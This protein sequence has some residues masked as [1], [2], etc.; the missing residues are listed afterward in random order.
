M[1][2]TSG[3][4]EP[5]R[6]TAGI[7]DS[8]PRWSPDGKRLAFVRNAE[9]DGKPQPSQIYF[10]PMDGGEARALANLPKAALSPA[11]APDGKTVAFTTTATADDVK[12]AREERER[13][14]GQEKRVKQ[15]AQEKRE[16]QEGQERREGQDGR[17]RKSDVKVITR[18]VYRAN[19]NPDFLEA[20]RHAH[21]WT[22]A[23]SEDPMAKP[24]E[25]NAITTGDF[26]ER[27][28]EWAPD[29]SKIYFTSSRA[30]EP[31]YE[32]QHSELYSVPAAGGSVT[33]VTSIEGTIHEVSVSRDG[34]RIAFVGTL[35]GNPVRSYS[36]P[37]LWV[38]DA[39]PGSPPRN[40]TAAYDFDIDGG[41]G[42]DQAA[43]R[44]ES[45]KPVVWSK[46]G[47]SLIVV[48]AE[49][50]SAN[51]K[52]VSIATGKVEPLTDGL[53]D[54]TAYS[55]TKPE[56]RAS[57]PPRMCTGISGECCTI[58][59]PGERPPDRREPHAPPE[60]STQRLRL[61]QERM[62]RRRASSD[63]AV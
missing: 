48:S 13:Q 39:A 63:R 11:W 53:Q 24:A 36:Q 59:P 37:D 22:V 17:E 27:I 55:A 9:K 51:L 2:P 42:G 58:I 44:G 18:A 30:A 57:A 4:E 52:R 34:R 60:A 15:D 5:R 33:K 19:G 49:H 29:G 28:A 6:I 45:R 3:S 38:A 31:Y 14:E 23:V 41:I 12:K 40:L 25:P 10:L 43:P 47:N 61:P 16:G 20:D 8:G 46:D 1:V 56:T 35:H 7:R 50:G 21:I 32:P 54:V 62:P 26:D